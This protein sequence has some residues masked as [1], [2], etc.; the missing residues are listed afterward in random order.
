MI[1]ELLKILD[2]VNINE[3]GMRQKLE[4]EIARFNIFQRSVLGATEKIKNNKDTD[5]RNFAKYI[6]KEG[7]VGEKRELLANLRS[8]IVYK[9]KKLT[10]L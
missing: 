9:D 2:K 3:L 10:L 1:L 4:D 5:I 8:R 6:L 7:T